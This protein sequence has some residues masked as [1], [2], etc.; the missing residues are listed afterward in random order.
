M[1]QISVD[2]AGEV[3]ASCSDDRKVCFDGGILY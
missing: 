1:N 2:E 3:M